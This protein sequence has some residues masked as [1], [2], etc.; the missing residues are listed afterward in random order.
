ME[1]ANRLEQGDNAIA[2]LRQI[3]QCYPTFCARHDAGKWIAY[4]LGQSKEPMYG[5]ETEFEKISAE[6]EKLEK[7]LSVAVKELDDL[8]SQLC[9]FDN[10][11]E[12]I[13]EITG[14]V[15]GHEL[16]S[17]EA[18]QERIYVESAANDDLKLQ[19]YELKKQLDAAKKSG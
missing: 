15:A 16:G 17:V 1:L 9:D 5:P 18:M 12:A 2:V 8:V 6:K 10:K 4:G 7:H 14:C 19:V 3:Q 11:W 13:R